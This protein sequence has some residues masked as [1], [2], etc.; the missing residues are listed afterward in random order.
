VSDRHDE[1]DI[2]WKPPVIAA[3]IGALLVAAFVIYAIV[4]G[5]VDDPEADAFAARPVPSKDLPPGY[6]SLPATVPQPEGIG[7]KV[8]WVGREGG[9]STVVVSS[10]IPGIADPDQFAPP[11]VAFWELGPEGERVMMDS[12]FASDSAP[13]T[14]TIVFSTELIPSIVVAHPVAGSTSVMEEIEFG[15]STIGQEIPIALE[16]EPDA[17]ITGI[18]TVG[19]GWGFVEWTAPADTYA[20]LD[21][22]ARFPGTENPAADMLEPVRLVPMYDSSLSRPGSVITPTPLWSR[23]GSY[24]L[25]GDGGSFAD[26]D[27]V[28]SIVLRITGSIVTHMDAPVELVPLTS[29]G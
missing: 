27:D 15:P 3:I 12:Q 29:D 13:G 21:V 28:T 18:V 8:E 9:L 10:A 17:V 25:V 24:V 4:N 5:P 1:S 20:T 23:G 16:V 7:I 2:P 19:D 14:T 22:E 11:D 6:V 26:A